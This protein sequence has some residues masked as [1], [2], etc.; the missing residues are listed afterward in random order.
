MRIATWN[1]GGGFIS[2][3]QKLQFNLERLEYFINELKKIRPDIVCLQEI[4]V[5]KNNN[6]PQIIAKALGFNYIKTKSVSDSHQKAGEKLAISIVSKFP[7]I[8]SK[9]HKLAN[10]NLEFIWKG[11][12]AF[13]HNKGFIEAK[14]SY[15]DAAIRILSG[16]MLPFHLFGRDF[17]EDAFKGIRN[18]IENIIL[19]G[20]TPTIIGADMNFE[21]IYK[22]VPNIFERGFKS[23]LDNTPTTPKGKRLDKIIISKKWVCNASKITKGKAG[24]YLC[25]ADV[26]F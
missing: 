23:V 19:E 1:I 6:Q 7:I 9:F 2:S 24:H 25:F 13:S 3:V 5:S 16:H 17:L 10:P 12:K 15:K 4:H 22:L 20:N 11:N 26:G 18:Q 14:I 21:D 8:S